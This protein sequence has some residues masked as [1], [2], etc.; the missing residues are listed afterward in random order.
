MPIVSRRASRSCHLDDIDVRAGDYVVI[1][2]YC[3]HRAA[4]H[5]EHAQYFDAHRFALRQPNAEAFRP[6][7]GG[8]RRCIGQGM[9]LRMLP[10]L[11][12][13]SLRTANFAFGGPRRTGTR[14]ITSVP[15]RMLSVTP[16]TI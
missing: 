5:Y 1:S 12:R 13:H 11:L 3:L 4:E 16:V 6:F 7:G 8:I 2:I 14:N 15:E 9:A 10:L